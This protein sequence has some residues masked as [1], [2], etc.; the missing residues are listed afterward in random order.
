[1]LRCLLIYYN[2]N[3]FMNNINNNEEFWNIKNKYYFVFMMTKI[4]MRLYF[5]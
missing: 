3:N 1:M 5:M 4:I 2:D